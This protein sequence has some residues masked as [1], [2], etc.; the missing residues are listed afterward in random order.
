VAEVDNDGVVFLRFG[1]GEYGREIAGATA[2]RAVYRVGNGS[3]GNVGAE[4]LFH[5]AASP[6]SSG[7][8]RVRNPLPA[9]DGVE[10]E[11]IPEVRQRAPQAFRA[12]QFR[13]VTEADYAAAAKK[14]PEVS[15]AVASFRWTGSW[16]TVFV[17]VDP[18]D[19][20]DLV[21]LPNGFTTLAPVLEHKVRAFLTRYR[22]AGYDLEIRPPRFVP[23]EIDLDLCV[24]PDYFRG[25]VARVVA[26]ALSSG[27]LLDGTPG[28]FHPS[29]F[30]FG[31]PVYISQVYAAVTR[32]AGVDS[33]VVTVFHRYGQVD[34]GEL[35]AGVL[36]IGPWEIAQLDNDPNFMEHGVLKITARGGKL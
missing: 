13:A 19:P 29:H 22:L 11:T 7:V 32:V 36:P 5:V 30:A 31:Q 1:D 24:H 18:S 21:H 15:S 16:Y 2:F 26:A 34:N 17:G 23:L 28:F 33:A 4:A 12:E 20:T 10:P 9:Q 14:L 25:D 27:V 6:S 8:L 35:A 3:L